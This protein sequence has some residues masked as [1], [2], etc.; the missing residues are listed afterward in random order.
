MELFILVIS[1]PYFLPIR[2]FLY[3]ANAARWIHSFSILPIWVKMVH[4]MWYSK[5]VC[6]HLFLFFANTAPF[7]MEL[8]IMVLTF[9]YFL[10]IWP[11]G[12]TLGLSSQYGRG[13]PFPYF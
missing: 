11:C 9:P 8:F 2:P 3:F 1:I 13:F 7:G 10:P 5:L 6:G 12:P 4:S